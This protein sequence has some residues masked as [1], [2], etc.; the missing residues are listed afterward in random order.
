MG[1]FREVRGTCTHVLLNPQIPCVVFQT[2]LQH[3]SWFGAFT[4]VAQ[5]R[6]LFPLWQCFSTN[7]CDPLVGNIMQ[8]V[9][10]NRHWRKRIIENIVVCLL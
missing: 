2:Q 9:R 3:E 7:G 8:L 10:I 1:C 6:L 5:S 4:A